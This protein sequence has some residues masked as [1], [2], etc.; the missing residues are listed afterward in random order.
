MMV[1]TGCDS[2]IS[3]R[4]PGAETKI[5]PFPHCRVQI[6]G[7]VTGRFQGSHERASC[8]VVA[9]TSSYS[10][11]STQYCSVTRSKSSMPWVMGCSCPR[12]VMCTV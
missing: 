8:V 12:S 6:A 11:L 10:S 4:C 2:T 1:R 3:I 5:R 9:R 7:A